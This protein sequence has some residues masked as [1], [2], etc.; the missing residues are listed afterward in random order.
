MS[1]PDGAQ[2]LVLN[3]WDAGAGQPVT[4]TSQMTWVL[5][6]ENGSMKI[7]DFGAVPDGTTDNI[8]AI[9]N[10]IAAAKAKGVAVFVPAGTFAYGNLITLTGVKLYGVGDTSILHALDWSRE[11]IFMYGDGSEVRQLSLTGVP[12][13]GRVAPWEATRITLFGARSFRDRSCQRA[14]IGGGRYSDGAGRQQWKNH[15]QHRDEHA[16]RLHPHHR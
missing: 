12:A 16:V 10:A 6:V 8:A 2:K 15:Q 3:A 14:R 9:T 5:N 4:R 13:P 1:L 11:S 7:T